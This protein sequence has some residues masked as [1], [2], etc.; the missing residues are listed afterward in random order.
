MKPNVKSPHAK[1]LAQPLFRKRVK[2]SGKAY[3][4]KPRNKAQS[5]PILE[6]T[7]S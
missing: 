2:P 4:R 5:S 7:C 3:K 1:A 6:A